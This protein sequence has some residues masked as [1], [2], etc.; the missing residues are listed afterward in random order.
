VIFDRNN[1]LESLEDSVWDE[2]EFQ[3]SLTIRCHELRKKKLKDF[4]AGD[5][6]VMIGQS[7]SLE[8]LVPVALETLVK[9]PF[10]EGD[11]YNGDL[12]ISVLKIDKQFWS[13]NEE[14]LFELKDILSSVTYTIEETIP[15][16]NDLLKDYD[17]PV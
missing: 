10:I 8:Y 9:N 1:S 3:S 11:F 13:Q 14:L 12:L 4:S 2:P 5:L 7:I 16:I 15:I 17:I 6:R